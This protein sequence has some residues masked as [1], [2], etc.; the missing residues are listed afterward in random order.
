MSGAGAV[1]AGSAFV[2]IGADPRKFFAALNKVN[3]AIGNIGRSLSGAGAKMTGIGAAIGAPIALATRQFA[4]FDDAIRMTA[5][6]S[7]ASGVAL[8]KLNDTSRELGATTSFTA[9]Q[10][11]SLMTELG[12]AGFKP[13]EIN[14]MTG[15]VLDLAR[16]TGTDATLSAGIMAATLRQF[17]LEAV[18]AGR[19]ADVLT[20][21]ANST[22][23]TVEGL[24]ESLKYAGPVAKSLGLSLEDTTAVL[25]VLGNVGIQG[26]EAGT[27][28]RRLSVIAAGSGEELQALFGVSNTDAAGNLKPLVDI[29]DEI[30]TATASMPVAERTAKMAKAFGLLGITS[31]N[32]LSS[33]A[34]G[35]RGLAEQLRNAEGTAAKAAK[36]MDAGLGGAIRITLSAIEGTALAIGDA[37]APSLQKLIEGIGN[38]ATGITAFVK[39]NQDLV[40]SFAKGLAIFTGVGIAMLAVGKAL[41]VVSGGVA[42]LLALMNPIGIIAV[43][44]GAMTGSALAFSGALGDM[45]GIA[46]TTFSGVY[47]AITSGDLVGAMDVL[48]AGLMAGWLRGV[49]ALMGYV[50]PWIATFQNTFTIL[51][52]EIYKAWDT[53]WVT[54][55]NAFRTFGAYLQGVFDNIVNGVLAQWDN[56][57]AGIIKSWNYIQSFFKKGFNLKK[58]NEK[59]DSEMAARRRQ[60]ELDRP[61]IAGRT[62]E[63]ERQNE[64]DRK[65][66]A[67]RKKAVDENTQAT[68]D[69]RDASNQQRADERRANTQAA[70]AN[71]ADATSGVTERSRDAATA[72][73]LMKAL[74]S[75]TSLEEITNI[76]ASIDAL[77]ERGNV[78]ADVESKLMDS[79]YAAF[80]RV[81]V[82]AAS[83]SSADNAKQAEQ[84]ANAAGVGGPSKGDTVGTFSSSLSGMG[85]G[86]S[87]A[88]KQLDTLKQIE[89][90][91][92]ANDEG[93]VGA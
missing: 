33:S 76:G 32:V 46:Q 1:R 15:A 78:G 88:Q 68:I 91:T 42:I 36:E 40:L 75:A 77:L 24:G 19:A 56:L 67:D 30:N 82:A 55:G 9:V 11:A 59:V 27:A 14:A 74:G 84:G 47:T 37:L 4:M 92:S 12:R 26:S 86:T 49:E 13:D 34:E 25:G 28:L 66:L 18:D 83:A 71:L 60:R 64:Q 8:Q 63:A 35:V 43:T 22:F 53:T 7:G 89:Q 17:G 21:A 45:A 93:L 85:I 20:K 16:A 23:N 48:W 90:N 52:A 5:A 2:E 6:V 81:N 54:L 70:E 79:Y 57:E 61:G 51:G 58:E 50:D 39:A 80:S 73:E 29:L 72:A 62:A 44:L 38:V 3:R 31:A 69:A 10:V 87:L 65:D 41:S